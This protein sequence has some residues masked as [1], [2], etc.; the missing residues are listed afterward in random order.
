MTP[1]LVSFSFE[2]LV[3]QNTFV[4]VL[5]QLKFGLLREVVESES[6]NLFHWP[7]LH[8]YFQEVKYTI[9]F[10]NTC[11]EVLKNSENYFKK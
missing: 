6:K 2:K 8:H 1:K 4:K 5:T 11:F 3:F 9:Q 10:Y 7:S